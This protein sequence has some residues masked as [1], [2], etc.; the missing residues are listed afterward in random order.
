MCGILIM[1]K[2]TL[3]ELLVVIAIIG[4][5]ASMLLPS[6]KKA[7]E[8][9]EAAVCSSNL[10]QIG[11]AIT[12]YS[13]DY[14]DF[15]PYGLTNDLSSYVPG[16]GPNTDS[17]PLHQLIAAYLDYNEQVFVCPTDKS[18]ENFTWWQLQN[19]PDVSQSSYGSNEWGIWW[20]ARTRGKGLKFTDVKNPAEWIQ[21]SDYN[22]VAS[23][24]PH[25]YIS[26]D[27]PNRIDWYHP[28]TSVNFLILDGHIERKSAFADDMYRTTPDL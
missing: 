19:H 3:I 23:N 14:S 21:M 26:P 15:W 18:P 11:I 16:S 6:L 5:L 2:F 8:A 27:G 25:W 28:K 9:T 24:G 10:R 17:K 4:I 13:T 12:S 20:H 7:R 22:H 1:R